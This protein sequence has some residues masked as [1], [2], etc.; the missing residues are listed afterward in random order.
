MQMSAGIAEG[1]PVLPFIRWCFS[2]RAHASIV[3]NATP[4]YNTLMSG[5]SGG[6]MVFNCSSIERCLPCTTK[7]HINPCYV[8]VIEFFFAFC[9]EEAFIVF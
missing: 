2:E 4:Q 5:E 3:D 9:S 6:F 8:F 1:F 7:M